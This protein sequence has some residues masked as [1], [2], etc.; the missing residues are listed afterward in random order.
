VRG[1]TGGGR[2][3]HEGLPQPR[4]EGS[5]DDREGQAHPRCH[6]RSKE[7]SMTSNM[8]TTAQAAEPVLALLLRRPHYLDQATDQ[9]LQVIHHALDKITGSID[10][11]LEATSAAPVDMGSA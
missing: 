5:Q 11:R 3:R 1:R 2:A 9:E 6:H 8:V 10:A 4:Q 7:G